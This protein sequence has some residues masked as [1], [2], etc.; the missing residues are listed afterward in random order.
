MVL[1]IAYD[2][3]D[4]DP[5]K[6]VHQPIT[7]VQANLLTICL[8]IGYA[9]GL[10]K[11]NRCNEPLAPTRIPPKGKNVTEARIQTREY[12]RPNHK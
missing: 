10:F 3:P 11:S 4:E 5:P 7:N 12:P 1:A 2:R 8:P 6:R 9:Y